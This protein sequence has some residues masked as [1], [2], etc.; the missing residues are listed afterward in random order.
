M[1]YCREDE[2][3]GSQNNTSA[4]KNNRGQ[5]YWNGIQFRKCID[6][7]LVNW[8][9]HGY[10]GIDSE[11]SLNPT[12]VKRK[13]YQ[14]PLRCCSV[15]KVVID[16]E[17][18]A[19]NVDTLGCL[20][21]TMIAV[22]NTIQ[23]QSIQFSFCFRVI[24]STR[25]SSEHDGLV[26]VQLSLPFRKSRHSAEWSCAPAWLQKQQVSTHAPFQRKNCKKFSTNTPSPLMIVNVWI[27]KLLHALCK[28]E[29]LPMLCLCCKQMAV[30]QPTV[31]GGEVVQ[32]QS[33]ICIDLGLGL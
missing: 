33:R 29:Q 28:E 27:K 3:S 15:W 12:L 2:H 13:P 25:G 9:P 21:P 7:Q 19:G 31:A 14:A 32:H 23:C 17:Q 18:G 5:L 24:Q 11:M 30:L 8:I 22:G 26:S 6:I 1:F 20:S 16:A 4:N 10:S